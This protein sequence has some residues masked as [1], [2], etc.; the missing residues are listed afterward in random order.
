LGIGGTRTMLGKEDRERPSGAETLLH[1]HRYV[2]PGPGNAT[3]H[4][5][6]ACGPAPIAPGAA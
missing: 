5:R 1:L 2:L 3:F 4:P 6:V